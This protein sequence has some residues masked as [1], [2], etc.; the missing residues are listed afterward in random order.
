MGENN[1][2]DLILTEPENES[3]KNKGLLVILGLVVLLLVLG[4][5]LANVIFGSSDDNNT[6][7]E[8]LKLETTQSVDNNANADNN[9]NMQLEANDSNSELV[10]K[11]N[12]DA[13]LAPIDDKENIANANETQN[14][15]NL[16][17]QNEA[18]DDT[19]SKNSA[20]KDESKS[21]TTAVAPISV[22]KDAKKAK[23]KK[24]KRKIRNVVAK[25]PF[26]KATP[27]AANISYGGDIYIQ[28]GSF[29]KGPSADFIN[30]IRTAG[31]KY[32]IKEANG[33]RRVLIG[34]FKNSNDAKNALA[35]VKAKVSSSAFIKR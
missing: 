15:D 3:G 1:L 28:V 9:S 26:K 17:N 20:K 2:D 7:T 30:K 12:L 4:V 11:E 18:K 32:K 8:G 10:N 14:S 13:E 5:V 29:S 31:F 24:V 23:P 25:K 21:E 19:A 27:R 33:Y 16:E 6:T 22:K 35:G 34:P